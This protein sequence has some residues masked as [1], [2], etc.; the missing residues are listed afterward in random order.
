MDV[1]KKTH[2]LF[3]GSDMLS[4]FENKYLYTVTLRLDKR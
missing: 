2:S 3:I 4:M 1:D